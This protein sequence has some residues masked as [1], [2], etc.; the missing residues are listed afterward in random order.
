MRGSR[1]INGS[2][3]A[4]FNYFPFSCRPLGASLEAPK[5]S[6]DLRSELQQLHKSTVC[7]QGYFVQDVSHLRVCVCVCVLAHVPVLPAAQ[8]LTQMPSQIDEATWSVCG[9]AAPRFASYSPQMSDVRPSVRCWLELRCHYCAASFFGCFSSAA[10]SPASL[11]LLPVCADDD[12][13]VHR[14]R[15]VVGGEFVKRCL[16]GPSDIGDPPV[17]TQLSRCNGSCGWI[18]LKDICFKF[19]SNWVPLSEQATQ[20]V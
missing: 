9:P 8:R 18:Q 14:V 3:V 12:S 5:W 4:V 20:Y 13:I 17:D 19:K 10:R 11:S 1:V 15:A 2:T 6:R 7:L 16:H